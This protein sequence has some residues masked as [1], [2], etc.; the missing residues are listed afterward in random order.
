[1]RA[2]TSVYLNLN[3]FFNFINSKHVFEARKVDR[4]WKL[5]AF[6]QKSLTKIYAG[7]QKTLLTG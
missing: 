1:M 5:L 4:F 2:K 6:F 3:L 7:P